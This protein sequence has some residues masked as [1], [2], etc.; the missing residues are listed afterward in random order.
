[1]LAVAFLADNLLAE[2]L[3]VVSWRGWL[4]IEIFIHGNY[5][6]WA[7]WSVTELDLIDRVQL[8]GVVY[9]SRRLK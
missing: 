4:S 2:H 9:R 6:V 3:I 5:C 7:W 8:L 1:M